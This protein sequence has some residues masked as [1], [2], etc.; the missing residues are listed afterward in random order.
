MRIVG[1]VKRWFAILV[2]AFIGVAGAGENELRA[3][4]PATRKDVIAAIDAQ[5]A[6]FRS[7]DVAR[8]YGFAAAELRAQKP[9]RTFA[10]IV[11][12]NYPEIWASTRAEF[13]VVRDD[14]NRATVLVHVFSRSGDAAYDYTLVKERGGWRVHDVLRHEKTDRV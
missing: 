12:E 7:G 3:S 8:A 14:G 10:L 6:A 4:R 2:L 13:G 11:Q 1:S 5:L 9:L